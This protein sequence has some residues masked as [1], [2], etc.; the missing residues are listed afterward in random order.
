MAIL[1]DY[2]ASANRKIWSVVRVDR[3]S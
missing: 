2:S 3:A 1:L